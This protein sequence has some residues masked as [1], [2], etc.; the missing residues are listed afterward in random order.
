MF[1]FLEIKI[2]L[3]VSSV[4]AKTN[5]HEWPAIKTEQNELDNIMV[6]ASNKITLYSCNVKANNISN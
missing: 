4:A 6:L 5:E 1:I 2:R 3:S